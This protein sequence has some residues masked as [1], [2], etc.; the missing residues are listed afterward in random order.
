MTSWIHFKLSTILARSWLLIICTSIDWKSSP[1]LFETFST[2]S[3][4]IGMLGI[5]YFG[6]TKIAKVFVSCIEFVDE[7]IAL[8]FKYSWI[9]MLITN[10][11][12][13]WKL[14]VCQLDGSLK[15]MH[16]HSL[17]KTSTTLYENFPCINV[18]AKNDWVGMRRPE[19]ILCR[20]HLFYCI[21]LVTNWKVRIRGCNHGDDMIC[22][23]WIERLV[24]LAQW[25]PPPGAYF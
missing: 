8:T 6:G 3:L 20:L 16:R 14:C 21:A 4:H 5:V 22:A 1:T 25:P 15:Q 13:P 23:V 17:G 18:K 19:Y 11:W 2:T 7:M 9:D 12:T 24:M 10:P